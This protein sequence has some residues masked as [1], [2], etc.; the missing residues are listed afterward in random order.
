[1]KKGST[2]EDDVNSSLREVKNP[3]KIE[4]HNLQEDS[5]YTNAKEREPTHYYNIFTFGSFMGKALLVF[6]LEKG[7]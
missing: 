7:Q 1:M 4:K 5:L 3:T 2:D 6:Q